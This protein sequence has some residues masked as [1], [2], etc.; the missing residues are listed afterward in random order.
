MIL[1]DFFSEPV[2]KALDVN[3]TI[4]IELPSKGNALRPFM[5]TVQ[6]KNLGTLKNALL[7]PQIGK[8]FRNCYTYEVYEMAVQKKLAKYSS[9]YE[10]QY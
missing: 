1:R 9:T 7:W 8:N 6:G 2:L 5:I 4:L 10:P 3:T